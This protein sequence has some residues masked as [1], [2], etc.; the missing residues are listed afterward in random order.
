MYERQ[1]MTEG[2]RIAVTPTDKRVVEQW[3]Q[4]QDVSVSDVLRQLIRRAAR[5]RQAALPLVKAQTTTANE[6]ALRG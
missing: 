6:I 5:E 2:I 1:R 4:E 3:A